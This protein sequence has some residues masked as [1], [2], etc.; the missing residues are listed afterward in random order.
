M[1]LF[2]FRVSLPQPEWLV[3]LPAMDTGEFLGSLP[4]I[5]RWLLSIPNPTY[6]IIIMSRNTYLIVHSLLKY[7]TFIPASVK[8]RILIFISQLICTTILQ[9]DPPTLKPVISI[10]HPN[11]TQGTLISILY[12]TC[13]TSSSPQLLLPSLVTPA[14]HP[15]KQKHSAG[16][17]SFIPKPNPYWHKVTPA[18]YLN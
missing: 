15:N 7:D 6:H 10:L 4:F 2:C 9:S 3:A 1:Y 18:P 11:R 12:I 16:Y 17:T 13:Y 14:L 8:K 5:H